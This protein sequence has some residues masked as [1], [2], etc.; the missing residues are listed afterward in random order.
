MEKDRKGNYACQRYR[1]RLIDRNIS[2]WITWNACKELQ[3]LPFE[4][5]L[6]DQPTKMVMGFMIISNEIA[7]Y[8]YKK[9]KEAT[10]R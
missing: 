8:N 4:G 7:K 5:A 3:C 1:Y 10:D 6:F 2:I 9:M